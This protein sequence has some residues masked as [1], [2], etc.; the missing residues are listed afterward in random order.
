M[1]SILLDVVLPI[2]LVMVASFII[3]SLFDL[4]P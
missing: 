2:V 3:G 1:S 4:S